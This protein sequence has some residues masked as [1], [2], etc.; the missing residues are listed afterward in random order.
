MGKFVIDQERK[1]E[2]YATL[3]ALFLNEEAE[4]EKWADLKAITL[5]KMAERYCYLSQKYTR[6]KDITEQ[7]MLFDVFVIIEKDL[8]HLLES[9]RVGNNWSQQAI[10]NIIIRWKYESVRFVEEEEEE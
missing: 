1:L 6:T 8:E 10:H 9:Y 3:K 2:A 4:T 7:A 5:L